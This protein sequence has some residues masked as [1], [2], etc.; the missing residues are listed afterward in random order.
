MIASQPILTLL[1]GPEPFPGSP[2]PASEAAPALSPPDLPFAPLPFAIS[3]SD[4]A[5]LSSLFSPSATPASVAAA[6]NL[7]HPELALWFARS[8]I[9]TA[10]QAM[11]ALDDHFRRQ[12][13]ERH[14][15]AAIETLAEVQQKSDDLPERRRAASQ[16]LRALTRS[17]VSVA[18]GARS[19]SEG[20]GARSASEESFPPR[21][22]SRRRESNAP[23]PD[24]S[25]STPHTSHRTPPS[26]G[27]AHDPVYLACLQDSMASVADSLAAEKAAAREEDENPLTPATLAKIDAGQTC[28]FPDRFSKSPELLSER[29]L[30]RLERLP[31]PT[32]ERGY[33]AVCGAIDLEIRKNPSG[34]EPMKRKLDSSPACRCPSDGGWTRKLY[35]FHTDSDSATRTVTWTHADGRIERCKLILVRRTYW[36][37]RPNR[38]YLSDIIARDTG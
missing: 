15:R 32:G 1:D 37:D 33:L 3:P 30:D 2:T 6:H 12:W 38:W 4:S 19:A 7:S 5:L 24:T 29:I 8:D 10:Y 23:S 36:P 25:H 34:W 35:P 21:P 9:Q 31:N 16:I 17:R 27:D 28:G 11:L 14:L 26:T 20:H 22:S 13:A 18:S